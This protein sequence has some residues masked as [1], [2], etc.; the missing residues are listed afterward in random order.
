MDDGH[1]IAVSPPNGI[2]VI[3][4]TLTEEEQVDWLETQIDLIEKV[5]P[6]NYQQ[7]QIQYAFRIT[8]H[9]FLWNDLRRRTRIAALDSGRI[10]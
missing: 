6:E 9:S 2:D 8:H 3:P 10:E 4:R 5:G 1:I 7:S